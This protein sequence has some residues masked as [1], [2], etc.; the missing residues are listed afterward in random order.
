MKMQK[1]RIYFKGGNLLTWTAFKGWDPEVLRNVDPN[2]QAGNVSFAGPYLGTPQV[3][4]ISF[5]IQ[6]GF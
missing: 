5:G 6:L 2:S 3:R 4:T 1:F